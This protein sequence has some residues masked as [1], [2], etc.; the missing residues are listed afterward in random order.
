M[1][2]IT[3][4][5]LTIDQPIEAL[6]EVIR[7]K[8]NCDS[9]DFTYT[10]Y[11]ESID[12]RQRG[13]DFIFSYTADVEIKDEQRYLKH[14]NPDIQLCV[15][16]AYQ[17]PAHGY[18][19]L[20]QRPVI[21]GFGPAGIFAGLLL[22]QAGFKPLILERGEA[23]DERVRSVEKFWQAGIL[24]EASNV[25]FGEGG[26]GTFSDGKLT[27]RSKD[28]RSHKVLEEFVRFGAPKEILYQAHPH[29]GTDLLRG[30]V[31]QM[32]EEIRSLGGEVRF[33]TTVDEI[34]VSKG[35]V[36]AVRCGDELI[37]CETVL[38][39][40]GHSARD[41]YQMLID[42]QIAMEAKAFAVGVRIEHPQ[43]LINQAQY[44][45]Y[46]N[47][48]RLK[49]A[50]YRLAMTTSK[51]RGVYTF[52]MCPG[53]NVVA[54]TSLAEHV[55][56]NGMSYH[57]RDGVNA[58]SALLVQVSPDDFGHSLDAGIKFQEQ[59]EK[60]A[61][62]A[63]G[64]NYQAPIQRVEDF[65]KHQPTQK[66]GSVQPSYPCGVK[67][68][69]FH[70]LLPAFICESLAEGICAFD[71]K[72][73]GFAM[74][75]AIMTGVETRSSSPLRIL[76]DKESCVSLNTEGLYPCGEGAGFAGGIVS[77]AIDGLRCAEKIIE[78]YDPE[79]LK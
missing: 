58:N 36:K 61:F 16:N 76:R 9:D 67:G 24:N 71:R 37:D 66:I 34:I 1:L 69:D 28:L 70:T 13:N 27:S 23:V 48:P 77:A 31:K 10:I 68:I 25:Q 35:A 59:L 7:K 44:K 11:K 12:A 4:L 17:L 30:I 14:K 54:S 29:I 19:Y 5:K 79:E 72:L 50:E 15:K 3:Q 20:K 47:H 64:S 8:L 75:D 73:K 26:A 52:C 6:R 49:A 18:L 65:L 57:A 53:G 2:R 45:Q 39:A 62:I 33:N 40:C 56:T 46:A 51:G 55:V 74:D 21:I 22:A 41:T 32:R 63:G 42:K 38:L 78:K 43:A 60:D